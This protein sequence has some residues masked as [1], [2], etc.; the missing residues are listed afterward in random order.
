MDYLTFAM[1]NSNIPR[2]E[3][4]FWIFHHLDL[5]TPERIYIQLHLPAEIILLGAALLNTSLLDYTGPV[6]KWLE[7][8]LAA[9]YYGC[10]RTCYIYCRPVAIHDYRHATMLHHFILY[11]TTN[12]IQHILHLIIR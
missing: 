9:C 10:F 12:Y 5:C 3:G 11:H 1:T 8:S 6:L 7:E 2:H 4:S